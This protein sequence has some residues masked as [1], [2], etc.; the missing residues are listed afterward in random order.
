MRYLM[1]TLLVLV[2]AYL[3]ACVVL[4]VFQS[5]FVF[6]PERSVLATPE[7]AGLEYRDV[8]LETDDGVRL[9]GWYVPGADSAD[10]LLFFH[11]NAGNMSHRLDSIRLFYNLGLSVLIIDYRGYGRSGGRMNE[12]GSYRDARAAFR[13]LVND[14]GIEP[15]N[16]IYFGRS[17][18][19][20][21][22]IELA[23]HHVPKAIIIESCFPS[24]PAIGA[25]LY[26]WLPVRFLAR[27]NYESIP[28][29]ATLSCPK[30]FIHSREDEMLPYAMARRLYD[31][32][33]QPKTFLEIRGD[34]N[35]GF[36]TSGA[37]Y[38]DGMIDFLG[39]LD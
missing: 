10:V 18:G 25:R 27:I 32:A 28:R 37:D 38:V 39:S 20:A 24:I 21:V 19:G 34:H 36:I 22:A 16:I 1:T 4:F 26:P 8:F 14:M 33:A 30:L 6:F 17:L 29:V 3:A 23:T 7:N 13:Y 5:R 11:G 15:A 12:Q 2:A 9:N 31:A 35:T